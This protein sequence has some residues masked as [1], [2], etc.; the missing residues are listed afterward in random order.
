MFLT[1]TWTSARHGDGALNAL[2]IAEGVYHGNHKHPFDPRNGREPVLCQA[3]A[4]KLVM[5]DLRIRR[6]FVRSFVARETDP[7]RA[8]YSDFTILSEGEFDG[9]GFLFRAD[10]WRSAG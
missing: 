5:P 10:I 2:G 4:N 9:L 1:R 7:M 3:M 6:R 8:Q